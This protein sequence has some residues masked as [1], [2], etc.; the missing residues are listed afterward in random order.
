MMRPVVVFDEAAAAGFEDEG[1]VAVAV[2]PPPVP[3]TRA[4]AGAASSLFLKTSLA[5][6]YSSRICRVRCE[7]KRA[8]V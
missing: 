3:S 1:S 6:A 2:S 5:A 8:G 4:T 7:R